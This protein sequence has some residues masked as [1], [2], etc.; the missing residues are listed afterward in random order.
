M[1]F[2]NECRTDRK[3]NV[4]FL[5]NYEMKPLIFNIINNNNNKI[6]SELREHPLLF[7]LNSNISWE[8]RNLLYFSTDR[9]KKIQNNWT[10]M[11]P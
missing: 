10:S 11:R 8:I 5:Q 3:R 4:L 6:Q 2:C 9:S 7:L 1:V